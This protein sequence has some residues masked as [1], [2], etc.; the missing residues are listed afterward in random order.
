MLAL[1]CHVS[2][3][4]MNSLGRIDVD[5]LIWNAKNIRIG[6]SDMQGVFRRILQPEG[7]P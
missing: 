7:Y 4:A 6:T 1:F 3:A 5:E 2:F